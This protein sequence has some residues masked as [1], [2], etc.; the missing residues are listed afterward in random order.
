MIINEYEKEAKERWGNTE[1]YKQLTERTKNWT[2]EDYEQIK[3]DQEK[4]LKKIVENMS[5]GF[6]DPEIQSL[7]GEWRKGIEKFYD[8]TP[9]ICRGLA[10]MYVE[11]ERFA[12]FYRKHHEDLPEFIRD[13][14]NYYCDASYK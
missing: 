14:I 9:Q 6:K 11:D 13:A 5:K 10:T 2:K 8:T 12:S 7:I 4:L 3:D 1:A